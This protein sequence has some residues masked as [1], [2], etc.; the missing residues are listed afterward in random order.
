MPTSGRTE[1]SAL[2]AGLSEKLGGSERLLA[3]VLAVCERVARGKGGR[4]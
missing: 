3:D 4:T 1:Y 2:S